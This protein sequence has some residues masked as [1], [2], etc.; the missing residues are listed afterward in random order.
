[1]LKKSLLFYLVF[2]IIFSACSSTK[3]Q[4]VIVESPIPASSIKIIRNKTAN[5]LEINTNISINSKKEFS[6]NIGGH[7]NVNEDGVYEVEKIIGQDYFIE[8]Q[9]VNRFIY[10]GQNLE[11]RAPDIQI[12]IDVDYTITDHFAITAGLNFGNVENKTLLGKSLGLAIFDE[13][14]NGGYRVDLK[15]QFQRQN[16][17]LELIEQESFAF[18]SERKVRIFKAAGDA[19]FRNYSVGFSYNTIS[20]W[21]IDFFGNLTLGYHNLYS[22]VN[23]YTLTEEL[24]E[25]FYTSVSAGIYSD[26]FDIT[27]LVAGVRHTSFSG[28]SNNFGVTNYFIQYDI[29]VF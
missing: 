29:L 19:N 18:K 23:P 10:T 3:I 16:F 9:N 12:N 17:D 28:E 24:D 25:K 21:P 7:S 22:A 26:L 2:V 8:K 1:M 20:N 11:W 5:D 27:R 4:Q 6:G 13:G 15:A 14:K